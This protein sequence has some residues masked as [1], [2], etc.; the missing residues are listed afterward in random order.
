ML[1]AAGLFVRS[2][3][4]L[5]N[6]DFGIDGDRILGVSVALPPTKYADDPDVLA[7]ADRLNDRLRALPGIGQFALTSHRP[8]RG[9]TLSRVRLRDQDPGD[10]DEGLPIVARVAVSPDYFETLRLAPIAGRTFAARDGGPAP[11]W[12]SWMSGSP[13]GGGPVRT[14]SDEKSKWCPTTSD[15]G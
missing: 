6:F 3:L 1:V 4:N 8:T 9:A 11:T 15:H 2:F 12:R 7:F 14:R 10:G 13:T 5:R